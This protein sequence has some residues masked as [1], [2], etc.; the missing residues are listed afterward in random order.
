LEDFLDLQLKDKR[1]LVLA[2]SKGIGAGIARAFAQEGCRVAITSS[3]RKN[4]S[5][6]R[7]AIAE[8]TGA[9]VTAHVMDVRRPEDAGAKA[10]QIVAEFDGIDIAVL[11][12]PGPQPQDVGSVQPVDV[13]SAIDTNLLSGIAVVNAVLPGMK[14]RGFGR[15]LALTSSTAREPDEGMVLSSMARAA[16]L[17][18][19]K[20]LARELGPYGITANAILTGSVLTDRLREL[21]AYKPNECDQDFDAYLASAAATIP[22]RYIPTPEQFAPTLVYLASPIAGYINGVALPIDGGLMRAL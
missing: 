17:A 15:I 5:M 22:A 1:A 3:S 4:I 19:I 13:R 16:M 8:E 10:E 11:N 21:M 14:Q 7:D 20:T 18:Y 2:A 12:G 9:E 6:R